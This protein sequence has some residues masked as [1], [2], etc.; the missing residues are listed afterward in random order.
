MIHSGSDS[1]EAIALLRRRVMWKSL[2]LL[3]HL[4][5]MPPLMRRRTG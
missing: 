3:S 5:A 1:D 4:A 2:G